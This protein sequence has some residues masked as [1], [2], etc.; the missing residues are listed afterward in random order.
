MKPGRVRVWDLPVRLTHWG[1]AAGVAAAWWF[2]DGGWH[3][4]IGYAVAACVAARLAWGC[5][6]TRHARF[7]DFV[8]GPG[9]T[10]AYARRLLTGSEPRYLG[11]NPLG[12]WMALVLWAAVA[13]TCLTGWLYTT[14][15]YF[16]EPWLDRLHQAAAW[17]VVALVP[18][19]LAGVW[20]TSRRHRENLVA[21]MLHGDK[22]SPD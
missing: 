1:V 7:G 5:V 19:H 8:R 16:G 15:A 4:R 3:E 11:H 10:M 14:D 12:G 18:L 2:S 9:A 20:F 17:T 13:L 21:A 6:G 22:R